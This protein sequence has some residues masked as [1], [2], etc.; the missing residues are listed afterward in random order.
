MGAVPGH[1][2]SWAKARTS[3][4]V[5]TARLKPPQRRRPVAGDPGKS[6]PVTGLVAAPPALVL[7]LF[8]WAFSA[9]TAQQSQPQ[10][11]N[12][13]AQVIPP[14]T[15]TVVVHGDV[16]DNYL[17][18]TVTA[19]TLDGAP[20]SETPL[21]ATVVT[22]DLLNDQV[23]RVLSD[24]VKNDASIGEDYAP[25]GYYG[26]FEIRG[27]PIDLA[28][29]LEINGMTIAGEQDVPLENKERVELLKGIAGVESGVASAGGLI[30]FI[31]KRPA[32]DR[33]HRPGHRSSRERVRRCGP[34]AALRRAKAGRRAAEPGGRE[35]PQLT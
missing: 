35:H 19:G 20:L 21:S 16:K 12:A 11:S 25:V 8:G 18:E 1:N 10:N 29:G 17:P 26:D 6:C 28:T 3:F 32:A 24:V 13:P 7:I 5:F 14:V 30:D 27:F 33:S 4:W 23:S 22:R 15:T 2:R 31:T 34:G 9:A